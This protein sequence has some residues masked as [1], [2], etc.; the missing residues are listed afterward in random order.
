MAL[1]NDA[2]AETAG[3][4]VEHRVLPGRDCALG[5]GEVDVRAFFGQG[6]R[7]ILFR[8]AVAELCAAGKGR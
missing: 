3:V 2:A 6:Y 5:H 8:L 1:N 4:V 7:Y